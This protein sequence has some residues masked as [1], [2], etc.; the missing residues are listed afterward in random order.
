MGGAADPRPA[1]P[2]SRPPSPPGTNRT[3]RD[4]G[5]SFSPLPDPPQPGRDAPSPPPTPRDAFPACD[6]PPLPPPY[7]VRCGDGTEWGGGE[8]GRGGGLGL[9]RV[10]G[11]EGDGGRWGKR[12]AAGRMEGRREG[13]QEAEGGVGLAGPPHVAPLR[14]PPAKCGKNDAI[15]RPAV[16]SARPGNPIGCRR[17]APGGAPRPPPTFKSGG[18]GAGPG[19][20]EPSRA[21]PNPAIAEPGP[22]RTLT[23]TEPPP[24]SPELNRCRTRTSTAGRPTGCRPR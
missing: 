21:E 8:G 20:D 16:P 15:A 11:T 19:P 22:S 12:C 13:R 14:D 23:R 5:R 17:P 9:K 1:T 7:G 2:E 10:W 4:V 24:A 18:G 6:E 3:R